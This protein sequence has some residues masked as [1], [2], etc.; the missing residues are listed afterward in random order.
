[1]IARDGK[2]LLHKSYGLKNTS[3]Q[4]MNDTNCIFQIGSM[5]KSFTS[6]IILKLREE[7][8]LSVHDKLSRFIPDYPGGGK[9]T[10]ENLLTHTSGIHNYTDDISE[11]DTNIICYPVSKERV[12]QQ[13]ENKKPEFKPGTKFEYN[14]SAFFLLG[15]VIEKATGMQYERVVRDMIFTPLQMNHSGFDFRNLPDTNKVTGYVIFSKDTSIAEPVVDSTVYYSAGAIYSTTGDLYR[16]ASA[17]AN[18]RLLSSES[19]QQAFMNFHKNNYG[20]GFFVDSLY[21]RKYIRHSGGALGLMSEYLYFPDEEVIVLLLNNFG[22]YGGS[23]FPVASGIASIVFH[24]PY[25]NWQRD[26]STLRLTKAILESYAGT[27]EYSKEHRLIVTL[28]DSSLYVEATNPKDKLPRVRLYALDKNKFYM[29]E[30]QLK[31]SFLAGEQGIPQTLYTYIVE[32]KREEWKK[33]K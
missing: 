29:K 1:M 27:Y 26:T 21:G 18:R 10:I 4:T 5:T 12:L 3:K 9:I 20:Y 28:I 32:E 17:I 6:M 31:F 19:W 13:F 25:S 15:M 22:N 2:V 7:G 16:W 11:A 33:I 24:L 30:A 8:L 23:L 14:N